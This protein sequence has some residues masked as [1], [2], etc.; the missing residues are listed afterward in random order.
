MNEAAESRKRLFWTNA[1]RVL[2]ALAWAI[3]LW[4]LLSGLLEYRHIARLPGIMGPF[5]ILAVW[6]VLIILWRK[7]RIGLAVVVLFGGL[8][9]RLF[10]M[11]DFLIFVHRPLSEFTL[12]P[13]H[14]AIEV[15]VS[16]G[17]LNELGIA[18]YLEEAFFAPGREGKAELYLI[19]GM[20]WRSLLRGVTS[21]ASRDP[22]N[23]AGTWRTHTGVPFADAAWAP[24]P[25]RIVAVAQRPPGIHEIEP[26]ELTLDRFITWKSEGLPALIEIEGRS[27]HVIAEGEGQLARV[28]L[29]SGASEHL[30]PL[31]PQIRAAGGTLAPYT[32]SPHTLADPVDGR[33]YLSVWQDTELLVELDERWQ[34]TRILQPEVHGPLKSMLDAFGWMGLLTL[35]GQRRAWVADNVAG[36]GGR[37]LEIDLEALRV[38]RAEP[39]PF[40]IRELIHDPARRRLYASQVW[41]GNLLVYD[42]A[43]GTLSLRRRISLGRWLRVLRWERV[44]GRPQLLAGGAGGVFVIDPDRL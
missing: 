38:L 11:A 24:T 6:G 7:N 8:S 28:D 19:A 34:V 32:F 31:A 20:P 35:P 25:G 44:R 9:T 30:P 12:D 21:V 15:L 22:W 4:G 18:P 3:G 27:A 37:L 5:L 39:A 13:A 14:P 43:G 17:E 1:A 23:P 33:R 29:I 40:G 16:A 2:R 41:E 10:A 42:F 36:G 26:G